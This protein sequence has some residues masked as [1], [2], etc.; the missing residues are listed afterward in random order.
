MTD[1]EF[2]NG[3]APSTTDKLP[4]GWE[5]NYVGV[6]FVRRDGAWVDDYDDYQWEARPPGDAPKIPF[7]FATAMAAMLAL[8]EKYPMEPKP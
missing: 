7:H 2:E 3:G 8:N 1:E 5:H 4:D 6:P